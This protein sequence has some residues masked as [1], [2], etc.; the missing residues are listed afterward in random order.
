MKEQA[1]IDRWP[2]TPARRKTVR[3]IR[4]VVWITL[5]DAR[6]KPMTQSKTIL[7]STRALVQAVR[8]SD[9][10][11]GIFA[12]D[13]RVAASDRQASG[14]SVCRVESQRQSYHHPGHVPRSRT[15]R[16][17]TNS[18]PRLEL[19]GCWRRAAQ[20]ECCAWSC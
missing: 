18:R 4:L 5:S 9:C 6:I 1:G 10:G 15:C 12:T 16:W 20:D 14:D 2:S 17:C 7:K 3:Q 19:A 13:W 11:T 8:Q